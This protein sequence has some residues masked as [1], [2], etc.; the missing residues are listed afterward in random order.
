MEDKW[1]RFQG[2][3]AAIGMLILIFDSTRALEGA[4]DGLEL[5]IKSVIPSLFPFFVL[6]ALLTNSSSKKNAFPFRLFGK[7][8][9]IPENAQSLLIPA[10]LGGYPVG[11]KCVSNLYQRKQIYRKEA[12]R[13]IA[14]CNNAGPAFLFGLVSVFFP[15]KSM[16]WMLWFIHIVSAA[17]TAVTIPIEKAEHPIQNC[18]DVV[19]GTSIIWPAVKAMCL[20]CCW[21]ILFRIVIVF[22]DAWFLWMLPEW[23]QSLLVGVLELT[24]GCLALMQIQNVQQRFIIC[25]CI[26]AFGGICV[27]FQTASV[28]HGLPIRYYLKGKLIQTVFSFLLSSAIMMERGL[29]FAVWIPIILFLFGK[30]KNRYRNPEFIPV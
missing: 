9:G 20:V 10:F 21:V 19:Q 23:L 1:D 11:A 3:A 22:L 6:S 12:A 8:L 24:N 26:L 17:L 13:L 18:E 30:K 7:V 15:E 2:I 28:T 16:I 4:R 25:S 27:M 29:I 5:C 14:F